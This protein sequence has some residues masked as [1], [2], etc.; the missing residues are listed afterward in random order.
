MEPEK[1]VYIY[2]CTNYIIISSIISSSST[3]ES[4]FSD[5]NSSVFSSDIPATSDRK[6]CNNNIQINV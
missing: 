4:F 6:Q 2:T 3:I 5:K 1:I